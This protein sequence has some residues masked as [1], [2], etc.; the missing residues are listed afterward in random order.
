MT[1]LYDAPVGETIIS[2]IS[3]KTPSQDYE[4]LNQ[5]LIKAGLPPLRKD[6]GRN[7]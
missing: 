7:F 3:Y 2:T 6:N 4:S 5:R 1:R